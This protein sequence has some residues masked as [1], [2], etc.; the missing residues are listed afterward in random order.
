MIDS[1]P[2]QAGM[3]SRVREKIR[4]LA[5]MSVSAYGLIQ[6][7]GSALI[8]AGA[9]ERPQQSSLATTALRVAGLA[10]VLTY[11]TGRLP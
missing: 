9:F 2:A 8:Y 10:P 4:Q 11:R 6:P 7:N 3:Q 5:A 1:I